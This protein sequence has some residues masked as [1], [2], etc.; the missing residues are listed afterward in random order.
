MQLL[1]SVVDVDEVD[2]ARAGGADILDLKNPAEGSLGAPTPATIIEVRRAAPRPQLLSVAIGDM[3][4]LPG[5]AALAAVGAAACGADYVKVGLWGPRTEAAAVALLRQASAAVAAYPG[6]SLIAGGY[7][8][9]ERAGTLDPCSLPAVALRGGA[10]GCLI[11]TAIKDGRPLFDFL[12]PET[13]AGL[14]KDA[15]EAGLLMALAGA[16]RLKDL[17]ILRDL[18]AD[19]VGI[20]SAACRDSKRAGPLE[21]ARVRQLRALLDGAGMALL[22]DTCA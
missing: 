8:D 6:V 18:G 2:A 7:A 16:I 21:A 12:K 5:T 9:A 22:T 10:T 4:D 3:P 19:I 1:I 13:L 20:R 14:I 11:D 15:H 17:P